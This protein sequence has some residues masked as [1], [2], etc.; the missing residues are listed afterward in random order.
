[1]SCRVAAVGVLA[2]HLR[3]GRIS[4]AKRRRG[5]RVQDVTVRGVP[6]LD[7]CCCCCNTPH[8]R[9]LVA[10]YDPCSDISVLAEFHEVVDDGTLPPAVL[11]KKREEA[12]ALTPQRWRLA[13][14]VKQLVASHVRVA[15]CATPGL[16][17][18]AALTRWHA[19]V[20]LLPRFGFARGRWNS[21]HCSQPKRTQTVTSPWRHRIQAVFPCHSLLLCRSTLPSSCKGRCVVPLV[22]SLFPPPCAH[23]GAVTVV[24][25]C[26]CAC[27]CACVLCLCVRPCVYVWLCVAV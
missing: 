2:H 11:R 27:A 17:V 26:M 6:A 1:M 3:A 5:R 4:P 23:L 25:G 19:G 15:A 13:N 24:C 18:P 10:P 7:C 16:L 22:L 14:I 12:R 9:P 20:L 8:T 21:G